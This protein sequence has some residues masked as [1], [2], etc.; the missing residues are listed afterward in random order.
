MKETYKVNCYVVD[1]NH[2][3][4]QVRGY[5]D[6]AL[7]H[8]FYSGLPNRIKDEISHIGKPCTLEGLQTLAQE[9]DA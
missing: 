4:S 3:A 5:S 6:G 1:F 8:I 7:H 2:L 9:I